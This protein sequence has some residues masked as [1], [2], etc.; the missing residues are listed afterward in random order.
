M[1]FD[2]HPKQNQAEIAIVER[3]SFEAGMREIRHNQRILH[4]S[5]RLST[6]SLQVRLRGLIIPTLVI[7]QLADNSY[8]LRPQTHLRVEKEFRTKTKANY[9]LVL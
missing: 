1:N 3:T 5:S 7:C 8:G 2:A 4:E 6:T 9:F